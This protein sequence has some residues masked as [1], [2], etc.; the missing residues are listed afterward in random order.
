MTIEIQQ[1]GLKKAAPNSFRYAGRCV[2]TYK[3]D[4]VTIAK[5]TAPIIYLCSLPVATVRGHEASNLKIATYLALQPVRFT[6]QP[7][8]QGQL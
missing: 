5:T 1:A 7:C 6:H 2:Q 8:Y 3:P 4:P